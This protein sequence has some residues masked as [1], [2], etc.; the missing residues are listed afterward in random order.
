MLKGRT[1][2]IALAA[3]LLMPVAARLACADQTP[4]DRERGAVSHS[5]DRNIARLRFA[6]SAPEA[7]STAPSAVQDSQAQCD[8]PCLQSLADGY[9]KAVVAHDPKLL[10]LDEHV[11]FTENGQELQ[12]GDGF[13][14]T[15]S[16]VGA[17]Q[18]F[19]ADPQTQQI[20]YFGTMREFDN[21]VLMAMRLKVHER[22]ISEVETLFYRKGAGP[23][24]SDAGIDAANARGAADSSWLTPVPAALRA[25]REQLTGIAL[26]WMGALAHY[27]GKSALPLSDDCIRVE[28]G[29]RV[30]GNPKV[31]IGDGHFNLAALGCRQQIQSGYFASISRIHHR[32]VVAVDP[33]SGTV[34][35]WANFD[36]AGTRALRLA[37]GHTLSLRALAQPA[38]TEAVLVFRIEG[39]LIHRIQMLT[40]AVP[41]HMSPG[42]E[43]PAA[44]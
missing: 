9:L 21:V 23:S 13:W 25:T 32:R 41:Y 29:T 33:E 36:Q 24:W 18:Q 6:P 27:D 14:N 34:V 42:W 37:D 16:G 8:R 22:R 40:L 2:L 39:G 44:P 12:P 43:E 4:D 5:R 17:A 11:R 7:L 19:Y 20:T 15:A 35:V 28:N 3:A 26:T 31:Q 10:S 38:S 1:T 30:S